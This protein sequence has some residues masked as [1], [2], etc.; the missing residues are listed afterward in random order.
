MEAGT[1]SCVVFDFDQTLTEKHFYKIL[2]SQT[3]QHSGKMKEIRKTLIS[4]RDFI[5]KT[6]FGGE[7]RMQFL[8]RFLNQIQER[9]DIMISTHGYIDDIVEVFDKLGE[10]GYNI[11]SRSFK[12]IHGQLYVKGGIFEVF[13]P[14]KRQNLQKASVAYRKDTF[15]REQSKNYARC[16][17]F[18]DDD[19]PKSYYGRLTDL[20]NVFTIET[21]SKN[22]IKEYEVKAIYRIFKQNGKK[23]ED[24][25]EYPSSGLKK[26]RNDFVLQNRVLFFLSSCV[27]C[28]DKAG[29]YVCGGCKKTMYC[30]EACQENHWERHDCQKEY[31]FQ[32]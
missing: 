14:R 11:S 19:E 7:E 10:W 18:I 22:G 12:L 27:S 1:D 31:L 21:Q 9:A 32:K 20:K 2:Y 29:A 6:V 17:I 4:D 23:F 16:L 13:D 30:G 25:L 15:I 24:K 26:A 8:S 3:N 28:N 5:V